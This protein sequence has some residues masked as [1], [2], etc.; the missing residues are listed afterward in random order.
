MNFILFLSFLQK[1]NPIHFDKSSFF[2]I[3][4]N[5]YSDLLLIKILI[6]VLKVHIETNNLIT[7]IIISSIIMIINIKLTI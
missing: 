2:Y 5:D 7:L 4:Y 6:K 3:F 1:K